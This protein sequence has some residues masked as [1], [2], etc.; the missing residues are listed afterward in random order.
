MLPLDADVQHTLSFSSVPD[1]TVL[2]D[3]FHDARKRFECSYI[4]H[5]LE[6]NDWNISKTAADI[7]ME[8]S[9]L[10]RKIKSH[11]LTPPNK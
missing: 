8:R 7:G 4:L 11:E 10:H 3:G 9:Q 6:K 1:D 2:L 5:H